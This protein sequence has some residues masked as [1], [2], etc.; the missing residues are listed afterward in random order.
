MIRQFFFDH[1]I[2]IFG[3]SPEKYGAI[4]SAHGDTRYFRCH[5]FERHILFFFG[6]CRSMWG[7]GLRDECEFFFRDDGRRSLAGS[8]STPH[9]MSPTISSPLLAASSGY[10]SKKERYPKLVERRP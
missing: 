7:S 1:D 5:C 10:R 4:R 8:C 3:F 6:S 2:I 9:A